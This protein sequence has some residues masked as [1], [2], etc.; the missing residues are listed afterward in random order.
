MTTY[1]GLRIRHKRKNMISQIIAQITKEREEFA[2]NF[3]SQ[4]E[5]EA[6]Y[7]ENMCNLIKDGSTKT[8]WLETAKKLRSKATEA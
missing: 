5:A 4:S 6:A 1:E 3:K 2:A 8:K 7:I